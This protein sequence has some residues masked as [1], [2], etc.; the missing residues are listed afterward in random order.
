VKTLVFREAS[1][2]GDVSKELVGCAHCIWWDVEGASDGVFQEGCIEAGVR[3]SDEDAHEE[4]CFR[5]G[6]ASEVLRKKGCLVEGA[7]G[8]FELE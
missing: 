7:P 6:E 1:G 2:L 3:A 8:F 4:C 5:G